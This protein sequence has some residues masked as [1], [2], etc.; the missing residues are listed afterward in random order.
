MSASLSAA[1][2][3]KLQ[4]LYQ[5]Y[6]L[7]HSGY[8]DSEEELKQLAC[9]V[10]CKMSPEDIADPELVVEFVAKYSDEAESDGG[11][12]FERF[13][14]IA[15]PG[16]YI[17]EKSV[18]ELDLESVSYE[19]MS[20]A[21]ATS[22]VV[23]VEHKNPELEGKVNKYMIIT[24]VNNQD[25]RGKRWDEVHEDILQLAKNQRP[26]TIVFADSDGRNAIKHTFV[27]QKPLMIRWA[28]RLKIL[29][30][31]VTLLEEQLCDSPRS[32]PM[33]RRLRADLDSLNESVNAAHKVRQSA[34]A[35]KL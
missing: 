1:Q 11:I 6:D 20:L 9:N 19:I 31:E 8:I 23:I 18:E 17:P 5:W 2:R 30:D 13:V 21:Q 35:N 3:D 25:I 16:L 10:M 34:M 15:V 32:N 27:D 12:D 14:H 29:N 4:E 24:T 26:L 7:D 33:K 28:D 22:D